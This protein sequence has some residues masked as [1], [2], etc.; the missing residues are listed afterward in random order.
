[1]KPLIVS[2]MVSSIFGAKLPTE[3]NCLS[4]HTL[5]A[6]PSCFSGEQDFPD[7]LLSKS[8]KNLCL[9]LYLCIFFFFG[10]LL[11]SFSSAFRKLQIKTK[12]MLTFRVLCF[13]IDNVKLHSKRI[14]SACTPT[15]WSLLSLKKKKKRM[16]NKLKAS[17]NFS[18]LCDKDNNPWLPD[19]CGVL[20]KVH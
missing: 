16:K 6:S 12:W 20:L 10:C 18:I 2:Q 9:K 14:K 5:L 7:L 17:P 8:H 13:K 19:K 1:M 4:A 11:F 3:V 15:I